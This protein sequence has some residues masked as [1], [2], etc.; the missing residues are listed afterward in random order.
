MFIKLRELHRC[1][2]LNIVVSAR[3]KPQIVD[4]AFQGL[5]SGCQWRNRVA[6]PKLAILKL[7]DS[8]SP[9]VVAG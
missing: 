8:D 4:D 3:F 9:L 6:Q 1:P 2:T 5:I 7:D